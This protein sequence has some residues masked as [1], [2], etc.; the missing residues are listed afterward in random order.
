MS[1]LLA[2]IA[3]RSEEQAQRI[4]P[5][6]DTLN[7]GHITPRQREILALMMDGQT[8]DEMAATL[9]VSPE[10]IKSQM[11]K[12]LENT[13]AKNRVQL[14]AWAAMGRTG[15]SPAEPMRVAS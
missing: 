4:A 15:Y 2:G 14:A 8:N 1:D 11:R 7:G 5:I 10:T 9:T 6:P 12:L 13:N 3:A